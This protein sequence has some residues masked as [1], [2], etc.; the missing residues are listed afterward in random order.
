MKRFIFLFI[1]ILNIGFIGSVNA[2]ELLL[3]NFENSTS[4][5][6]NG[7]TYTSNGYQGYGMLFNEPGDY[8]KFHSSKFPSEGTF[9][10]Y[11][12]ITGDNSAWSKDIIF[13]TNARAGYSGAH[14]ALYLTEE[15]KLMFREWGST[16]PAIYNVFGTTELSLNTWYA[17]GV[18]WGAQGVHIYVNGELDASD[19]SLTYSWDADE[20]VYLGDCPDDDWAGSNYYN[21]FYGILDSVRTSNVQ[22]DITYSISEDCEVDIDGLIISG[23]KEVGSAITFSVEANNTCSSTIYYRYTYHAGYGT[24][25]Y[26]GLHWNLM[27]DSEYTTESTISFTFDEADKYIVVVWAKN[28]PSDSNEGVPII[29][30]DVTIREEGEE[31]YFPF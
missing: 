27:T 28:S 4:G 25:D 14:I 9:E 1:I 29:G 19:T 7:A 23:T 22:Q 6:I 15:R 13:D 17:I 18:S 30:I 16:I 3:E 8:V 10:A 11:I 2:A 20:S 24:D 12:Y 26:D 21:S 31:P 5:T